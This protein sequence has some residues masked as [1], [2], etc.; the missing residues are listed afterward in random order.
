MKKNVGIAIGIFGAGL[1]IYGIYLYKQYLKLSN[2]D[3]N[4]V[5]AKNVK[6]SGTN[7]SFTLITTLKNSGDISATVKD[8]YYD[9]FIN[10]R[11]VSTVINKQE[12]KVASNGTSNI[13]LLIDLNLNDL[14]KEI[15]SEN[16]INFLVD[17]SK[18]KFELKGYFTFKAGL[19]SAKVPFSLSYNLQEIIDLAKTIKTTP[20]KTP[21]ATKP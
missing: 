9:I 18:V 4:V 7:V 11:K 14:R 13:P 5:G 1:T 10:G 8:Q 6:I 17:K 21:T 12:I 19:I 16:I 2:S 20:T 15:S 3:F